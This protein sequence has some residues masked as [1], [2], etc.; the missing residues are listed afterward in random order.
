MPHNPR[1]VL[2]LTATSYFMVVPDALVVVTALP[3]IGTQLDAA[4]RPPP[5]PA[6]AVTRSLSFHVTSCYV[7]AQRTS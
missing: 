4:R 5:P 6:A 3:K 2:G 7:E 1:A